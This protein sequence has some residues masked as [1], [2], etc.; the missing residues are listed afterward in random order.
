M[1]NNVDIELT[2]A[3]APGYLSVNQLSVP[4]V[5]HLVRQAEGLQVGVTQHE[6]GCTM[7]DAG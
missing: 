1:S 5:R 3:L 7:I 2:N 6:S 4:L